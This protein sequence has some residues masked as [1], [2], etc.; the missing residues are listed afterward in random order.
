MN[1]A[2]PTTGRVYAVLVLTTLFWGGSFLFTKLGLATVP[3]VH[4]VALRFALAT[5]IMLAV[6]CRRFS[7]F[8]WQ[9]VWRGAI[10]GLALG[11]TNLTFV[12]GIKGTSISRAGILNNLFVLFIPLLAKLIW[13][14]RIGGVNLVGIALAALGIGLLAVSGGGFNRGDL[15][16]TICAFCI[17]LHILAVSKALHPDDDV[18]LVSLVQFAVVAAMAGSFCLV[19]SPPT[20][21]MTGSA[22]ATIAYCAVFP[23]VVCFTLQNAFQRYTTATRAGLIYTLDPVWSLIAGYLVLGERLS[24]REWLGCGLIFAAALVPLLYRLAQES[25][26]VRRY[27]HVS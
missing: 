21:T 25:R 5:A 9:I 14:D 1:P 24:G 27:L 15:F 11:V 12:T 16:S 8:T 26:L 20:Y 18:Y 2:P 13:R 19:V 7:A 3:P 4:F 22:L 23:T 17:A 6:A 10:V